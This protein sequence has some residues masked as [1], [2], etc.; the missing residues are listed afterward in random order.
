MD[1]HVIAY[2]YVYIHHITL[3]LYML[4][5]KGRLVQMYSILFVLSLLLLP[6][7]LSQPT[8]IVM[9]NKMFNS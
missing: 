9:L 3:T 6:F 5:P 1:A 7:S 4:L 8:P 2:H